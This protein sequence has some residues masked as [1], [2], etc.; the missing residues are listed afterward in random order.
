M[1]SNI[2][3][4]PLT[5]QP[6]NFCHYICNII[7]SKMIPTGLPYDKHMEPQ[8]VMKQSVHNSNTHAITKKIND[9][10]LHP[11]SLYGA[12]TNT[13]ECQLTCKAHVSQL[14]QKMAA[15]AMFSRDWQ[16]Q[17]SFSSKSQVCDCCYKEYSSL[18]QQP[19]RLSID[20]QLLG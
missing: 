17:M 9:L 19:N 18:S 8:F 14:M 3:C 16:D 5:S 13:G 2:T 11:S 10:Y 15:D 6:R 4:E 7:M 1:A 20:R 12:A